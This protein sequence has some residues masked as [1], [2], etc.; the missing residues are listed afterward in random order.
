MASEFEKLMADFQAK[1]KPIS[2]QEIAMEISMAKEKTNQK[3]MS[4]LADKVNFWWEYEY[5]QPLPAKPLLIKLNLKGNK[6]VASGATGSL[7]SAAEGLVKKTKKAM[8]DLGDMVD[9][10][11]DHRLPLQKKPV[12]IT[13]TLKGD[14]YVANVEPLLKET[15]PLLPTPTLL[16]TPK[17]LNLSFKVHHD[18]GMVDP[19]WTEAEYQNTTCPN[20]DKTMVVILG[21][22]PKKKE[23]LLY[24]YC[25]KCDKYLI[26][27]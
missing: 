10:W 24:A 20:C 19:K 12:L 13:L 6:Y 3:A 11:W 27:E 15:Q 5:G 4:G 25:P 16:D 2:A 21:Y 14:K 18:E 22:M 23:N 17:T 9:E 1:L 7:L 26:G 8:K